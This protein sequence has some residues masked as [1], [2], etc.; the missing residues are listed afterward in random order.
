[1]G[2]TISK[3]PEHRF[4]WYGEKVEKGLGN[5]RHAIGLKMGRVQREG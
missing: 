3:K 1:M 4:W 5:Q 2:Q